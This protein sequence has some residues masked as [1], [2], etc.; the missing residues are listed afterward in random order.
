MIILEKFKCNYS[1][2]EIYSF[3]NKLK[4]HFIPVLNNDQHHIV[5]ATELSTGRC[6][7]LIID[8]G[9]VN[10]I[11]KYPRLDLIATSNDPNRIF[12]VFGNIGYNLNCQDP[13]QYILL[14]ESAIKFVYQNLKYECFIVFYNGE[15]IAYH[16]T[17]I[18]W[19]INL[20]ED[21]IEDQYY[22]NSIDD[23][24]VTIKY[25]SFKKEED[26]FLTYNLSDGTLL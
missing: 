10:N 11:F 15:I 14:G 22:I 9:D 6:Y 1:F 16:G 12:A 5:E 25:Y 26:I 19:R 21:I 24:T 23:L 3:D 20:D 17:K 8:G 7:N 2:R 13:N 18:L 4:S